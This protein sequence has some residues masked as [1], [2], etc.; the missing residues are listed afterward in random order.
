METPFKV[1]YHTEDGLEMGKASAFPSVRLDQHA[2]DHWLFNPQ[3]VAF[4]P[5][6]YKAFLFL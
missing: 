3:R 2:Y 4:R 6:S 1:F 5:F